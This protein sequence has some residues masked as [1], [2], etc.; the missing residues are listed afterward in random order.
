MNLKEELGQLKGDKSKFSNVK[1]VFLRYMT[2]FQ[3]DKTIKKNLLMPHFKDSLVTMN[4]E[5]ETI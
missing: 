3:K 1:Q 5:L 4:A 2:D